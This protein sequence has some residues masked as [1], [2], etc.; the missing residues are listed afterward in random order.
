MPSA[1]MIRGRLNRSRSVV[2]DAAPHGSA[3]PTPMRN[4][5][6]MKI[7]AFT[8]LNHGAPTLIVWPDVV[9]TS[10]GQ[11]AEQHGEREA[12]EQDVVEQERRLAAD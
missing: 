8:A 10:S 7:G 11:R 9:A 3:G 12:Q 5:R 4:S 6:A 1:P 2:H